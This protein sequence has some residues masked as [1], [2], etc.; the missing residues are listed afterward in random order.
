MARRRAVAILAPAR[1]SSGLLRRILVGVVVLGLACFIVLTGAAGFFT[2]RI[3]TQYNDAENV[4]P[5][6]FLLNNYESISFTDHLGGEHDGWLLRGLKGAPVIILCP[7]YDSNR[8]DL[9]SLGAV[10]QEN[11]FNVYIFNFHGPKTR[12]NL[13]SLGIDQA[14]D[15]QS[16]IEMITKQPGI[17]SHRVGLF[18]ATTGGYAALVTA[19]KNPLVTALAVDS[20]YEK[21][22][23][24]FD[25]ELDQYLGGP[26][27]FFR[28]ITEKEFQLLNMRTKTPKVREDLSKLS[29]IPKIFIS[30]RDTPSLA[31]ITEDLYNTAPDPKTLRILEHSQPSQS[32]GAEKKEYENQILSFFLQN[33]PLRAD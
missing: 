32:G 16:A 8:S 26:S 19:Q 21:P 13:S 25:A 3:V 22:M 33:L 2:F 20:I 10:L 17:N 7:G 31:S 15:L 4:T 29:T 5:A 14:E 27:T 1:V 12:R 24:M 23:Q 28:F 30:G 6:A 9:L 18:G 11:H